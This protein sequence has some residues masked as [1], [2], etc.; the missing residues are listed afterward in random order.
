ML[1][2]ELIEEITPLDEPALRKK[3]VGEQREIEEEFAHDGNGS[4]VFFVEF[5]LT[6]MYINP[7]VIEKDPKSELY[8]LKPDCKDPIPKGLIPDDKL[9]NPEQLST[10]LGRVLS[11]WKL[12]KQNVII[13]Y[14]KDREEV[15]TTQFERFKKE[16][17]N[18]DLQQIEEVEYKGFFEKIAAATYAYHDKSRHLLERCVFAT[19]AIK[20][21][22]PSRWEVLKD[23][24]AQ[25]PIIELNKLLV[26]YK[27]D[28]IPLPH[29]IGR[30][31]SQGLFRF[32]PDEAANTI[33][34][35]GACR[36]ALAPSK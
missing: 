5:P 14:L 31:T 12:K 23:L 8:V 29:S 13:F 19:Q 4:A 33:S 22:K 20:P 16:H 30:L 11:L 32:S 2:T 10:V 18:F 27:K 24:N 34:P 17:P 3:V 1:Q 15:D 21:D 7:D 28:P 6:P 9:Q 25:E 35:T 36:S 26:K